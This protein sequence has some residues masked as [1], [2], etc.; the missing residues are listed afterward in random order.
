VSEEG[1]LVQIKAGLTCVLV[2]GEAF[3]SGKVQCNTAQTETVFAI[4]SQI[5]AI[6][7]TFRTPCSII[8]T[9]L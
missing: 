1:N 4:S 9:R 8:Y 2:D 5:A 6:L 7:T 3:R